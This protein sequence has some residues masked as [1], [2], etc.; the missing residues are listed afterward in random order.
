MMRSFSSLSRLTRARAGVLALAVLALAACDD[1]TG[2]SNEIFRLDV[3]PPAAVLNVGSVQQMVATPV[4]PNGRILERRSITWASSTPAVATIDENG[5]V[6]AVAGGT[7]TITATTGGESAE[8]TLTVLFAAQSVTLAPAAG[9]TTTIRQ[10]GSVT[11]VPTVLANGAPVTGRQ[12]TWTS[13]NPAVAT[14]NSSGIVNGLTDGTTT[15]TARTV[16][17]GVEGTIPVTVSGPPV[18]ASV[19]IAVTSNRYIGN[20]QTEQINATARAAS[21]TVLSLAGR[22]VNWTSS[23][24]GN[25]S[26]SATGLVTMN[27]AAGTS[28]IG[29]SVDGVAQTTAITV[30]GNPVLANNVGIP[31]TLADADTASWV[32][33]VP[34]GTDTL[35]VSITGGTGDPDIYVRPPTGAACTP[36][37]NGS[38]ETCR[39][40]NPIAGRW[41]IMV[42]AFAGGGAVA[43][44]TLLARRVDNP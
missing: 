15:I 10:E 41:R 7:T 26:V 31:V 18:V 4:N 40:V 22:T 24:A 13:S 42:D 8:V 14:V 16:V 27:T 3:D 30:V 25:A 17:G 23:N 5:L 32:F 6:T 29:V 34:A 20:G 12:L 35:V 9:Q 2:S 11:I 1:S 37:L 39:I 19:T 33:E 21:G 44:G 38:N 28:S 43:G 36:F